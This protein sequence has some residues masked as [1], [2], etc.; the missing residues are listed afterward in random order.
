[1]PTI[2]PDPP[3]SL[4]YAHSSAAA[5]GPAPLWPVFAGMD[6]VALVIAFAI[7]RRGR[8]SRMPIARVTQEKGTAS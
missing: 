6:A 8:G 5:A 1:V 3:P 2:N 7:L 4:S